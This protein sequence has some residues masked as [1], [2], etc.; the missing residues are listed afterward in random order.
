MIHPDHLIATGVFNCN[1]CQV[2]HLVLGLVC[3]YRVVVVGRP[4]LAYPSIRLR[5]AL[6]RVVAAL[7]YW[8]SLFCNEAVPSV[9]RSATLAPGAN[10]ELGRVSRSLFSW[11]ATAESACS[12]AAQKL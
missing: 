11:S 12:G 5:K 10:A 9:A 4:D 3:L 6:F 1:I 7:L 2:M 8:P